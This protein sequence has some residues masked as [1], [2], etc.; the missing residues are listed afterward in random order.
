MKTLNLN[1]LDDVFSIYWSSLQ[2]EFF[3]LETLQAYSVDDEKEII[4]QYYSGNFE[5][6]RTLINQL[7]A[8]QSEF[9][10]SA[11]ERNISILRLHIVEVPFSSY[12]HYEL[13]AYKVAEQYGEKIYFINKKF[14]ENIPSLPIE[15]QDFLL[16][17]DRNIILNRFSE[18][19][20]YINSEVSESSDEILPYVRLKN[21]LLR[22]SV[23]LV[24]FLKNL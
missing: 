6:T 12:L 7:F 15:P 21:A 14:V 11:K 19:G 5:Q 16:F 20:C 18:Q 13:E 23:A 9:Y 3:K 8:N 4:Q 1:E 17:D 2:I 10:I 22:H 24:D